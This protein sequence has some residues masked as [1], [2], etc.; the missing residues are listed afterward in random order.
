[1]Q[2]ILH[3]EAATRGIALS[4]VQLSQFETYYHELVAWNARFNLTRITEYEAVQ[5]QHF[6]DSLAVLIGCADCFPP[7]ATVVDVGSG[8]GLPGLALKIARPD[9]RVTLVDAVGKKVQFLQYIIETLSLAETQAVHSRAEDLGRDR[10]RRAAYDVAVARAVAEMAVLAEYLLPLV[11]I[12]GVCIAQ[13]GARVQEEVARAAQASYTLGGG[14]T[15]LVEYTLPGLDAPRTLVV[16]PK[17]KPTPAMYPRRAG[18]PSQE[19]VGTV[20]NRRIR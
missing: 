19:P 6:L 7:D 15:R 13:K 1:M 17:L 20:K 8:A 9:L 3:H 5:I 18:L 12:G 10:R 4:D 11:R 14:E 16:V 2:E